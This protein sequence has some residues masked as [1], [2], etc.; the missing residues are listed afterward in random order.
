MA[1]IFSADNEDIQSLVNNFLLQYSNCIAINPVKSIFS[2][3][4]SVNDSEST[5][6]R[7]LDKHNFVK[8]LG[9]HIDN[10][11]YWKNQVKNVT[12]KRC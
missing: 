8:F 6:G 5:Y 10:R 4:N 3:V 9:M 7:M 11:L 1:Y 2:L 12:Q